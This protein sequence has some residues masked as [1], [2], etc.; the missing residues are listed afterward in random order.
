M[1]K[2]LVATTNR[3]KLREFR[4]ILSQMGIQVLSLDDMPEKI[5][6]EEDRETFLE[7]ALKKAKTYG[8]FYK[9]PV[10][11][12]DAGLEVEALDNYPGVYSARFYSI[13]YG[14]V[15]QV[16]GDK[17]SANIKKL[18]RLL[19]G[20]ENRR[21]RFVSVV[22][23]YYPDDF[24]LWTEGYCYGQII[25]EPRGDK[26]FGYDP[27]FVPEGYDKTMAELEPE[28]KNRIS[29]RGKAVRK[30]ISLL[31]KIYSTPKSNNITR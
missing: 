31:S 15:E 12:E 8:D 19:K 7:N 17:D 30:L 21:A 14:G 29:H 23:F 27:V 10:I 3:G 24:G 20:K 11:A 6:V 1:D 13:P 9:I 25:D 26:G 18:L 4:Q 28:E 2:L 5:D 16:D 22:V